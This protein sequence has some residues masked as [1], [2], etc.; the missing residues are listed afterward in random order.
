[1]NGVGWR[2]VARSGAVVLL[3]ALGCGGTPGAGAGRVSASFASLTTGSRA[4]VDGHPPL[5]LV[6]REGD[7]RSAIAV[8]VTTAGIASDRG[9]MAGVALAAL[10]EARL[11]ARG[12]DVAASGG[13]NGWRLRVL[14]GGPADVKTAI[15]SVRSAMLAP[16]AG[17]DPALVA[18]ARKTEAL[19]RRPLADAPLGDLAACTGEAY[20]IAGDAMP[21]ATDLEG[22][23]ARAHGLGRVAIAIAGDRAA[24]DAAL[25]A[26]KASP[27]WPAAAAAPSLAWHADETPAVVYDASGEIAAGSARVLVTARTPDPERAVS[28]ARDLGDPRGPLASRLAA[29]EAPARVQSVSATAQV[30]G[31]CLAATLDLAAADVASNLPGRVATVAALARQEIAVEV[32]DTTVPPALGASLAARAADPRDAAERAAWW[33]LAGHAAGA[34]AGDLRIKITVAVAAPRDG[35]DAA[36]PSRADAIRS[37]IDRAALAWHAPVVEKRARVEAGQGELWLLLASPCGTLAESAGDAGVGAEVAATAAAQMADEARD[38]SAEAFVAADG[39]GVMVHGP[40]RPGERPEAHAR[41]LADLAARAFAADALDPRK[42]AEA[43]T[44]LLLRG[45]DPGF[46]SL[47]ALGGAMAPGHP[48]WVAPFGTGAGLSSASDEALAVR[49]AALR[50]GPLRVAVLANTDAAQADAAARSVDRWIARRPGEA[51]T[52]ASPP[53]VAPPRPGTYGVDHAP[54]APSEA[55]LAWPIDAND[56]TA[57]A[58]ASWVAAALDGPDGLLAHALGAPAQDATASLARTWSAT[59]LANTRPPTLVVRITAAESSL[60]A[61]VAQT[62]VLL[63]R[64]RQGALTEEDRSRASLLASRIRVGLALDPRARTIALW[65]GETPVAPP[66]L[67]AMRAFAG[68]TLRDE[69]LVVVASRPPRPEPPPRLQREAKGRTR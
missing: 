31:G 61:S 68:A 42:T 64:V 34:G 2:S 29:L 7:G 46:R 14:L 47:A 43:R 3:A 21:T 8:A 6:T 69:G 44:T 59:V 35:S 54:G 23:R 45:T 39:I 50:S 36:G 4:D 40:A 41:R 17:D 12:L 62:R 37:E 24:S 58:T 15:D 9:A 51:R 63:D 48:S 55:L 33:T 25:L 28:A 38:A 57:T 67:D 27:P 20:S 26:L 53:S 56:V 52:C 13:W 10:V 30:D 65:R 32:A 19:R 18:V 60:D 1:V 22:W 11:A 49:A 16:V 5:A 66:S